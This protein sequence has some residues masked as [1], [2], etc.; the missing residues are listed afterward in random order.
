MEPGRRL[1]TTLTASWADSTGRSAVRSGGGEGPHMARQQ[2]AKVP[3]RPLPPPQCTSTHASSIATASRK[4]STCPDQMDQLL[5]SIH[6]IVS[7]G[8]SLLWQAINIHAAPL[9]LPLLPAQW[10][11]ALCLEAA[12]CSPCSTPLASPALHQHACMLT[13]DNLNTAVDLRIPAHGSPFDS[14]NFLLKISAGDFSPVT[15]RV[16]DIIRN[17]FSTCTKI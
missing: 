11:S 16:G 6:A 9:S 1:R 8:K 14:C 15:L 3:A 4:R 5:V 12:G 13:H 2:A 10:R 17:K 7:P